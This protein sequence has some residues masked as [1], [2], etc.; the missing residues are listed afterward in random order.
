M[1]I[2]ELRLL[3]LLLLLSLLDDWSLVIED[4]EN[5]DNIIVLLKSCWNIKS[6]EEIFPVNAEGEEEGAEEN[7]G[8]PFNDSEF[9]RGI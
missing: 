6:V 5:I 7:H 9:S 2:N 4:R 3:V 1:I 8:S